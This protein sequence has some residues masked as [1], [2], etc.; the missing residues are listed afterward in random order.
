MIKKISIIAFMIS[1]QFNFSQEIE[2]GK[3]SKEELLEE[4]YVQDPSADAVVLYKYQNTYLLSTNGNVELLTDIHERVKIYNKEGFDYATHEVDLFK[5]GSDKEIVTKIKAYTYNIEN[6][7]IVETTL[8]K[9]QIFKNEVSYNYDQTKFTM[10]NVK[11]GSVI[12]YKYTIRSPFFFSIDEFRFQYDIPIKKI[13]AEIRTP[14]G[15]RFNKTNKGYVGFFPK[16]ETK[17]D[18]RIGMNVVSTKYFLNNVPALKDES[19]V[20]NINNYRAGVMFE[21][22]SVEFPGYYKSYSRSWGDVAKTIGNSDDYKNKLDKTNSFKDE[23]EEL[24]SGKTDEVEKMELIFK[25]VKDNIKWNG[26]D[27]KGFYYGIK[28]ALKEKKGN[29]GD[30]NLTLVAML[31]DAGVK[32]N[33]VVIS[34]KDNIIPFFPTVDRLNYVIAYAEIGDK[35]YFM[36][37]TDEFSDI[38][39]LP[40]KDY[41]WKGIYIDNNNMIWKE[42][43]IQSPEPAISQYSITANLNEEGEVK[44]HLIA[45]HTNHG[46]YKFREAY[47]KADEENFI[48]NLEEKYNNIEISNYEV[49]NADTYNGYVSE[50]FD[51]YQETGADIIDNKIYIHPMSFLRLEEN[52]FKLDER[53]F[54]ID[55]GHPFSQ[56]AMVTIEIPDGYTLE[57]QPDP[58]YVKIPDDLGEFK[59]MPKVVGNKIQLLVNFEI[60]NAQIYTDHYLFLKEFFNQM[61]IKENEQIVLTKA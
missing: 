60:N 15:Y 31:R 5:S 33:P 51:Y 14:E 3:V 40:V 20:D 6:G 56:K 25:Y 29:A 24:L 7:K 43:D 54:P 41:N 19:Y 9:D 4:S 13:E 47:K 53:K 38:N 42:I 52:P 46:A 58:I 1:I 12:E 37:A 45:R 16:V 55:F 28:K 50:S 44:G 59:F 34:T 35:K 36:D 32:A 8:D 49:K 22:V 11:E 23:L 39:L 30:I 2:F 61:I 57:S 10:P 27:G 18:N 48:I 17:R 21:L 26:I